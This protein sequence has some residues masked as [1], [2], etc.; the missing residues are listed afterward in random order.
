MKTKVLVIGGNHQNPL[1]VIEGMAR[2]GILP[3]VIISTNRKKSFVLKSKNIKQSWICSSND[4]ILKCINE[5]FHDVENKAV[6]YACNDDVACFLNE[7]YDELKEFL[8]LQGI[9][10]QGALSKW[11]DKGKMIETANALGLRVPNTWLV[12]K[13]DIPNDVEYPCVTKSLT[14]V[15]NG[16]SEFHLCHNREELVNFLETNSHSAAI[17]VQQYIDKEFEFQY[18]GCSIDGGREI[19][20]PGRTHIESTVGFNNLTFLRYQE[21]KVVES[22]T[23]LHKTEEFI[24]ATGYSGLFSVEFMHGKDGKDYFLEMNFR[25]DGNGIVVTASGTNLPYIWYLCQ[26]GG[27]YKKE[28]A[29]SFVEETYSCPEDSYF[30]SMLYGKIPF[31]KWRENMKK[32]TCYITYFKD[33]TGPFWALMWLMKEPIFKAI[34]FGILLRLKIVKAKC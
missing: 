7:H 12:T 33:D 10:Q 20:I 6:V 29:D 22:P 14:S 8:I 16:K 3:Y 27:D 25:N 19:L 30:I 5:N 13:R 18:I 17:Q 2:K 11:M 9:S 23:I 4:E 32:V 24:R 15:K 28:I 34:C 26:T 21:N 31:K 1:G